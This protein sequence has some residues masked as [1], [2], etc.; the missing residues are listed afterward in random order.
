MWFQHP[1]HGKELA[2][3]VTDIVKRGPA[4]GVMVWLATQKPDA[5]SIPTSI[6]DM[7]ILRFCLK[8]EGQNANDSILGTSSYKEGFRATIFRRSDLGIGLL[9]GEGADPTIVKTAFVDNPEARNI[10]AR[11]ITAKRKAGTLTGQ[12]AGETDLKDHDDRTIVDHLIQAWPTGAQRVWCETLAEL[13]QN[14][15]PAL[16]DSW[17]GEQITAAVKPF[18][19]EAKQIK[20]ANKN[21][22]GLHLQQLTQTI[23]NRG[24][25]R[26]P[27]NTN[28]AIG[29]GDGSTKTW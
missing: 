3:I 10:L 16:F 4:V 24:D 13:L 20:L 18:G 8:V 21:R 25:P 26:Q 12:A 27:N 1:E 15:E 23:E 28:Q 9:K 19:I 7:A 5:K 6:T 29:G 17:T 11:A 2:E 14:K 22:R